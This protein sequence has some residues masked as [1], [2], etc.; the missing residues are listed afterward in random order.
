MQ[1][2][3]FTSYLKAIGSSYSRYAD[4]QPASYIDFSFKNLQF[5]QE[6]RTSVPRRRLVREYNN[7][8]QQLVTPCY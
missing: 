1:S 8:L 5:Q 3:I 7:I 2:L 4:L 6:P